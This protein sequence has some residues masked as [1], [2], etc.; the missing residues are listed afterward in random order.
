MA[1]WVADAQGRHA[2]R[3]VAASGAITSPAWSPDGA[4]IVYLAG[5]PYGRGGTTIHIV[6]VA[7]GQDRS[8]LADNQR[9]QPLLPAG[10]HFTRLAWMPKLS[11]RSAQ[12]VL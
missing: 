10:G 8:V 12:R 2:H 1:L 9:G 4:S 6:H 5:L 3:L 7:T 11:A